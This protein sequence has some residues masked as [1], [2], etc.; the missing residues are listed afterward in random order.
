MPHA[1]HFHRLIRAL[2]NCMVIMFDTEYRYEFASGEALEKFGYDATSMVGQTAMEVLNE[3]AWARVRPLYEAALQGHKLFVVYPTE[4]ADYGLHV[5]PLVQ[6][7]E[8]SGG[9]IFAIDVTDQEDARRELESI[10]AELE[11]FVYV[12]S[13]DLREPLRTIASF[14]ELLSNSLGDDLSEAQATYF[15]HILSGTDRMRRL[16]D[17]LL[18]YSRAGRHPEDD[19][20]VDIHEMA[21]A[22]VAQAVPERSVDEVIRFEGP[23]SI[24]GWPVALERILTNLISNS[25]KY[26]RDG[27]P[28]ELDLKVTCSDSYDEC[29]I[30][31]SDNG[32][33]ISD[34]YGKD[35]FEVFS[36]L[37]AENEIPGTG[38]GL[39]I[40]KKLV[41]SRG[42][43]VGFESLDAGTRFWFTWP[44]EN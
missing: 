27:V 29:I 30:S 9:A 22:C 41:E 44:S 43:E 10:N 28:L 7:D 4:L 12:A 21:R 40:V 13:H 23:S 33:G 39:S 38:I 15:Q 1:R 37:H 2:P 36:R 31:L 3:A 25:A 16:I 20:A 24:N 18:N 5:V 6:D 19:V 14:A 8:V 34:T 42:G 32:I 17:A 35:I 26:A 11:R